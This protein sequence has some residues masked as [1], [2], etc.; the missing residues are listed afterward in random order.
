M[1]AGVSGVCLGSLGKLADDLT[2]QDRARKAADNDD[3][4]RGFFLRFGG[5]VGWGGRATYFAMQRPEQGLEG[6]V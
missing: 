3:E 2:G 1:M 6:K 4:G 5:G